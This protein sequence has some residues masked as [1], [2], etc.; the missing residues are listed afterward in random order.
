MSGD[1]LL[2]TWARPARTRAALAVVLRW[3]PLAVVASVAAWRWLGPVWAI[4][5][6]LAGLAALTFAAVR[7]AGRYD[8]N[9][10]VR[11]LDARRDE[12]EDSAGLLFVDSATLN[13]FQQLQQERIARRLE[14]LDPD[15]L[16]E[17]PAWRGIALGWVATAV[18][19]AAI[20]LWPA[21][22][23]DVQAAPASAA[24]TTAAGPPRLTSQR[25]R[26]VPP[27]YTG[28]P[29]RESAQL[30]VRAPAGSRIE[31]ALGFAPDPT[32]V[33]LQLLPNQRVALR[34][35]GD[36]WTASLRLDRSALYR[37]QA[38]GAAGTPPLHRLEAIEDA[39]PQVRALVP[40]EGLVLVKPGQ[41]SWRV[42]LEATDDYGVN[43]VA[44]MTLTIAQGEGENVTFRE[45]MLM[46]RG[47]GEPRRRRFTA[48]LN[49]AALGLQPGGDLV[50]QLTVTDGRSPGP[51]VVRGPAVILRWPAQ[52]VDQPSGLELMSKRVLPAYFRSQRQI[53]IDT[54]ALIKQRRRLVAAAFTEKSDTIGV[55]Q[56]TLRLRYGQFLGEESEGGPKRPALPTND[57][58][59]DPAPTDTPTAEEHSAED[60]H[61]HGDPTAAAPVFGKI[62]NVT[63][64]FGHAHDQPEAATLLD[65]DTRATLRLALDQMWQ[66]ELHLRQGQ[67]EQAL[68]FAYKALGYIK[69]VQQATRIFLARVGPQLPPIDMARRMTGKREGLASRDT[70]LAPVEAGGEAPAAAWR[71]LAASGPV[72]LGPLD[73]WVRDNVARIR[74]PLSLLAAIETV[75][76]RPDDARSRAQL[77]GQL[78]T[79]LNRPPAQVR[80][81]G[82]GGATGRRYLQALPR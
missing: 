81:R 82:D 75:R 2:A 1:A 55:D 71:A 6:A 13:P 20:L 51:Q 5:V 40:T 24:R 50:A 3:A 61:D 26:I 49:L 12:L 77:R 27:G 79:V 45:R 65:P 54:E 70:P 7:I 32:A 41:R 78:W 16:T 35:E 33:A 4:M 11:H 36:R 19:V 15:A 47:L 60:G 69:Q 28:L 74:D 38:E 17:L 30:D 52:A 43:P 59:N 44:R 62:E 14:G 25:I 8:R 57:A 23:R 39:P 46:V 18:V 72:D 56:R 10:L 67:P 66:S 48:D 80:R 63:A 76:S 42:V 22:G 37:I 9:W 68:P 53:I 73:R 29:A 64:T 34:Q 31:W 21:T 58:E